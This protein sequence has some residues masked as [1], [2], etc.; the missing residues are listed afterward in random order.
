MCSAASACG[1]E[2]P[3]GCACRGTA[4]GNVRRSRGTRDVHGAA[5]KFEI[6]LPNFRLQALLG[7]LLGERHRCDTDANAAVALVDEAASV[8]TDRDAGCAGR[9]HESSCDVEEGHCQPAMHGEAQRM[10]VEG[11]R[12]LRRSYGSRN[13]PFRSTLWHY[14]QAHAQPRRR[15]SQRAGRLAS[16]ASAGQIEDAATISATVPPQFHL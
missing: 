4:R 7:L 14:V 5:S 11:A 1:C 15:G 16:T 6:D 3:P 2:W 13:A 12:P 8:G 10:S 9:G